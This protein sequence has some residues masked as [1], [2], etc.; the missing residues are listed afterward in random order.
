MTAR[1]NEKKWTNR[2]DKM[3]PKSDIRW[4]HGTQDLSLRVY[5][6]ALY[7][8]SKQLRE[9]ERRLNCQRP[10]YYEFIL[11][12]NVYLQKDVVMK[13]RKYQRKLTEKKVYFLAWAEICSWHIN[14]IPAMNVSLKSL[15][16]GIMLYNFQTPP[17]TL[18]STFQNGCSQHMFINN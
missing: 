5:W 12:L 2:W 15:R 13:E 9:V 16:A 14:F 3:R 17:S 4:C 8:L 18:P 7:K 1:S 11:R 6:L 10:W